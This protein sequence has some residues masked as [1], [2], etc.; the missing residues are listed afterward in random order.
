LIVA[1]VNFDQLIEDG[2]DFDHTVIVGKDGFQSHRDLILSRIRGEDVPLP[3]LK[4]HGSIDQVD[5]MVVDLNT[6]SRG[7]PSEVSDTLNAIV[8]E[9]G[10]LPWVW[11]GCSMRDADLGAWLAGKDGIKELQ[12][13]WVDPLPPKSVAAYSLARRQREWATIDQKLRDRQITETSDRFLS[14]LAARAES[15]RNPL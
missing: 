11:I 14:A 13:W 10:C 8:G 4:L 9:A 3:I 6:T 7:L 5:S 12:E 2:M 1:T 15:L